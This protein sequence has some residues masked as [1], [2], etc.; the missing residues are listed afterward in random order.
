M[1]PEVLDFGVSFKE[2][3]GNRAYWEAEDMKEKKERS[4]AFT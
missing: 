3:R 4:K 1:R 2:D